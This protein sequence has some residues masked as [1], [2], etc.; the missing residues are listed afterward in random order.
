MVKGGLYKHENGRDGAI[1]I[2]KS[3][4]IPEKK[5]WKIK[6]VWVNIASQDPYIATPVQMPLKDFFSREYARQ[7]NPISV[8]HVENLGGTR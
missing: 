1:F 4:Y 3:F 5:G 2:L 8:G 7:W 6:F